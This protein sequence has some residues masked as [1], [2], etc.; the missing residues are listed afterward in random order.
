MMTPVT[1]PNKSFFPCRDFGGIAQAVPPFLYLPDA[2][3]HCPAAMLDSAANC[4]IESLPNVC[5][6]PA[7]IPE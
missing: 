3:G 1:T 2:I 5:G 4:T 6:A 7:P